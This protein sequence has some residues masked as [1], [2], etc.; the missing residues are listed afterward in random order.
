[1]DNSKLIDT[2]HTGTYQTVQGPMGWDSV[3]K[4]QGGVGV[5]VEQWQNGTAVF[6]YPASVAAAQPEYPKHDWQ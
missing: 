3:G 1:M 6:V 2:L 4:P 5:F